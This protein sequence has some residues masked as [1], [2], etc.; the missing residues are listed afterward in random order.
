MVAPIDRSRLLDLIDRQQAQIVNV[1]PSREYDEER[2]PGSV[3]IPLSEITAE[4]ASRLSPDR[5]VVT[6]C[7]NGL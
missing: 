3:S 5:P 2:I 7:H 1:L 4:T 6:Y